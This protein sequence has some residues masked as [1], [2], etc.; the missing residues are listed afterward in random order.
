ME[1]EKWESC[2]IGE[3]IKFVELK[4]LVK[5]WNI[6]KWLKLTIAQ[7]TDFDTL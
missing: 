3:S 7:A 6:M 4:S 2:P 1:L 5:M